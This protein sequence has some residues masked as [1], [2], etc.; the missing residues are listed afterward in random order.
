MKWLID[1]DI[2]ARAR[3]L[4]VPFS[5][6]GIDPF[7]VSLDDVALMMTVFS[8]LYRRYFHVTVSGIDNVPGRGRG[9][10]VGNHSGGWALDGMMVMASMFFEKEPPRLAQGMVDKFMNRMP[11]ASLYTSRTG[12]FPGTPENAIKLLEADRLLMIFPEGTRGTAKLYGDR[13]TLV[14]FGTGF[15]RLALQT[16]TPIIPFAFLG[17]GEAVPTV[18]NLY[19][20]GKLLGVPYVPVTSYLL[21]IPRRVPLEVYYGEPM[22]FEGTGNEEDHVIQAYVDEVKARIQD[23]IDQGYRKR[24]EVA[25]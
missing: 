11:F 6:H 12:N 14:R 2:L 16:R 10:L 25:P 19:R 23:M 3:R 18:L 8:W 1:E 9:M 17:G 24:R 22:R 4:E 15:M 21:P 20:L 13:H 5:R 7:G